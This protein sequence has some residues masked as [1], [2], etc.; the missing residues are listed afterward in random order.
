M[1]FSR[2]WLAFY[3][4]KPQELMPWLDFLNEYTPQIY[5]RNSQ[6][7]I[8]EL[9]RSRSLIDKD[10]LINKT[11]A[12]EGL[13]LPQIGEAACPAEALA[14]A[15]FQKKDRAGLPIEALIY[16]ADPFRET[17]DVIKPLKKMLFDLKSLGVKTLFSFV[18]LSEREVGV[19]WSHWGKRLWLRVHGALLMA[20]PQIEVSEVFSEIYEFPEEAP[21]NNLEPLYFISKQLLQRLH[22]HLQQKNRGARVLKIILS[23]RTYE[24]DFCGSVEF[25]LSLPAFHHEVS[26]WLNLLRERLQVLAQ[27]KKLPEMLESLEIVVSEVLVWH[28]LQKDLLDPEREHREGALLESLTK[29]ESRLGREKI[30]CAEPRESYRPESSWRRGLA[31]DWYTL[32]SQQKRQENSL[33]KTGFQVYDLLSQKPLRVLPQAQKLILRDQQLMFNNR[34]QPFRLAWSEIVCGQFWQDPFERRYGVA[35]LQEGE[36]LWVYKEGDELYLQG[37]FV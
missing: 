33:E 27:Q 9:G 1:S 2:W 11:M 6:M 20:E 13:T 7:I 10:T 14:K 36:K 29:L 18:N 24:N 37:F 16:Y 5:V 23:G 28:G 32:V 12:M 31:K 22:Q 15:Q 34:W 35:S 21:G 8:F 4:S 25:E 17:P 30:F 19:R 3:W 26:L